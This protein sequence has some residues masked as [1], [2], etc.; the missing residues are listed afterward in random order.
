MYKPHEKIL[1]EMKMLDMGLVPNTDH[2]K[3]VDKELSMMSDED[4]RA[5]KRKWRKLKR[6]AI[7]KSDQH[8][9]K[10]LT[11]PSQKYSVLKMLLS[12]ADTY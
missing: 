9:S 1:L 5:A 11:S 2:F 3:N 10:K 8:K 4:A 12:D 7:K 6:R